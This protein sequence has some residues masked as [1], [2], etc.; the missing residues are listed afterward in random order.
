MD[1]VGKTGLW[2]FF[3]PDGTL[4]STE[5]YL[6]G[7]LH[8]R[9]E[10]YD[11]SGTL[12]SIENWASGILEDSAFYFRSGSLY[13]EGI[14]QNGVY[15][16]LWVTYYPDG[17]VQQ[18]GTYVNGLPDGLWKSFD[19]QGTLTDEGY[20]VNGLPDGEWKFYEDGKLS[21]YGQYSKGEEVGEWFKVGK[22]GK[23]KKLK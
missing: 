20:Y 17:T 12:I 6:S 23:I 22:N 14:Y 16:G 1:Q 10:N 15:A 13:R 3:Y 2:K 7:D 11:F 19:E 4:S 5:N 18:A 8:G 21:Y 9:S